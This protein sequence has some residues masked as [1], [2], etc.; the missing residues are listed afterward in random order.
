MPD[1]LLPDRTLNTPRHGKLLATLVRIVERKFIAVVKPLFAQWKIEP[2]IRLRLRKLR[3]NASLS[4]AQE[5]RSG[6][7]NQVF[8]KDADPIKTRRV[9]A[10]TDVT[11]ERYAMPLIKA[12]GASAHFLSAPSR[13]THEAGGG[14]GCQHLAGLCILCVGGRAD[15]YPA[16]RRLVEGSGGHF[17]IHRGDRHDI[18]NCLPALL[19]RADAVIC[20][21]D[22]VN[23][24]SF[25]HVKQYCVRFSKPCALLERSSLP[26][27]QRGIEILAAASF[28][29]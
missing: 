24:A 13:G 16:Y 14:S 19:L 2:Y 6:G 23:H 8:R 9:E 7:G 26:A 4:R 11:P 5:L 17:L 10:R 18:G 20:P 28:R 12:P 15:L 25:F 22:C 3:T 1:Y 27:F 21:V 29:F